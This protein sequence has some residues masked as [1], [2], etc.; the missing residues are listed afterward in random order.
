MYWFNFFIVMDIK[1]FLLRKKRELSS[2]STDGN[3]GKDNARLLVLMIRVLKQLIME[4][5]SKSIKIR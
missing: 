2:N 5:G 4:K 3:V 1:N